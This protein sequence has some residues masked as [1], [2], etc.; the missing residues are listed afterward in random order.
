MADWEP[1]RTVDATDSHME[2]KKRLSRLN[3]KLSEAFAGGGLAFVD[4][5]ISR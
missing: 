1:G 2:L 3:K 5:R 4:V